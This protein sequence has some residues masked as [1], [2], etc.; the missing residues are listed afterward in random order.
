MTFKRGDRVWAMVAGQ[1]IEG[2][3]DKITGDRLNSEDHKL[4]WA[5]WDNDQPKGKPACVNGP[6]YIS[7]NRCNH[8]ELQYD[9]MQ[10]GDKNDDI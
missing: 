8:F 2:T 6:Y 7:L 9:P 4:L 10:Q 1:R 3:V 5:Y